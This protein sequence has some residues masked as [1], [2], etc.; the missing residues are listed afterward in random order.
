MTTYWLYKKCQVLLVIRLILSAILFVSFLGVP[1]YLS[2]RPEGETYKWSI[3]RLMICL[4][5]AGLCYKV[6]PL[7]RRKLTKTQSL[8]K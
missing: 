5:V 8:L 1:F 4:A 2:V 6:I 3:P 7:V